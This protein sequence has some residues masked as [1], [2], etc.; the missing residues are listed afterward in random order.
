MSK[1]ADLHIHTYFSDGTSSPA[2]VVSEALEVGLSCIAITDHDTIDGIEP[3]IKIANKKNL[4]IISGI[5][6]SSEVDGKDIHILGYLLDIKQDALIEKLTQMQEVR[7]E[8]LKKMILK[9]K[10]LGINNIEFE[11]VA[12]LSRS[13]SVGRPH[14]AKVLKDKGWVSSISEAFGKYLGETSPAYVPK[15]KISTY[16]AI[17]FIRSQGGVSVLAHPM[18]TN[19]DELIPS[20]V[21]AGLQGVEVYYPN[22]SQTVADHYIG[23]AKKY[24]LLL[25]GGS[26]A[27]GKAKTS[28]FVG[29]I[30]IPYDLVEKLKTHHLK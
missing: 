7:I 17:K 25:T 24:N 16:E 19:R 28:T 23:L 30:K 26:D 27:H 3:T 2:E 5:E 12:R 9:L 6:L 15:Y 10:S 8:R 29:K 1:F 13:K 18:L 21:E 4:E 22:L 14:L 11:E 20:F